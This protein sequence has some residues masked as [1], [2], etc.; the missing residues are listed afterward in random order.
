MVSVRNINHPNYPTWFD[1]ANYEVLS[2]LTVEEFITQ[3]KYRLII[4]ERISTYCRGKFREDGWNCIVRGN[5]IVPK[6]INNTFE[7]ETTSTTVLTQTD[8]DLLSKTKEHFNHHLQAQKENATRL[9][10]NS[11]PFTA[12]Y[13]QKEN[14]IHWAKENYQ[15]PYGDKKGS[16][17]LSVDLASAKNEDI[18]KDVAYLLQ[19]LRTEL[20][21]PEPK[22][23]INNKDGNETL[24][25]IL[26]YK[27]IP[28]LD[29]AFY[30]ETYPEN[31]TKP[32]RASASLISKEIF[33]DKFDEQQVKR[34]IKP[35]IQKK[36]LHY[37]FIEHFFTKIKQDKE[38]LSRKM[39]CL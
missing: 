16:I 39:S 23:N 37:E 21:I 1:I 7:Q 8:L 6:Y 38:L 25:K 14:E 22:K 10:P 17:A 9:P 32:L 15:M 4:Q 36:V 24:K 35:F 5:I 13:N 26:D 20:N 29:L 31:Q 19:K 18:L 34:T 27:I 11:N 30:F 12:N 28:I 3:L 33:N 2:N